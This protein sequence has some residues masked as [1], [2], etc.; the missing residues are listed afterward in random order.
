MS[1]VLLGNVTSKKGL[2]KFHCVLSK[3]GASVGLGL[4][5]SSELNSWGGL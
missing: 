4:G 3:C 5:A 1:F 2:S